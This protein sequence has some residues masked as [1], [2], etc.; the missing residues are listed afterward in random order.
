MTTT[1]IIIIC[2]LLLIGYFFDFTFSKT[3]IPSVILLLFLGWIIRQITIILEIQIPNLTPVLPL[4]GTVGLILIVLEGCLELELNKSK[5][6]VIGKSFITALLPLFILSFLLAF[7]F[8]YFGNFTFKN[9]LLNAIPFC[10]ISS[11]IAIPSVRYLSKSNNEFI[12]YESSFSDIL[13]ILFFNFMALNETIS[14]LSFLSFTI[15]LL[16]I[17]PISFFATVGLAFLL[18]RSK[19]HIKYA[20]IILIVILI[21]AV[22]KVYHLPGLIF[23]LLFGIFLGNIDEF[24]QFSWFNR[25]DPEN[26]VQ[27]VTKFKNIVSESTFLIRTLFFLLF[28][29][30][31]EVSEVLNL[32]TMFW[33]IGIVAGIFIVRF[34]LLK[35]IRLQVMPLLFVAPRGLITILLFFSILP[36]QSISIV[37]KSLIVQII[38]LTSFIMMIGVMKKQKQEKTQV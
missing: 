8:Q 6:K 34:L 2:C 36:E 33:S 10:I 17:V 16:I 9:S 23:V 12:I 25:F 18:S 4:L 21:Y 30:L 22:S 35:I 13:G 26:L 15:Q 14:A 11:A 20:P 29:Y 37:N 38:I 32:E 28:G 27:E 1:I 3:K 24:K 19:H 5:I 31:V 7:L